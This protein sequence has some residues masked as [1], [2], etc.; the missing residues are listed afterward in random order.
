MVERKSNDN[1]NELSQ[2]KLFFSSLELFDWIFIVIFFLILIF[3][4][5]LI[6]FDVDKLDPLSTFLFLIIHMFFAVYIAVR[7][8]KKTVADK[9]IEVQKSIAKT[10]IRQII[11]SKEILQN[12]IKEIMRKTKKSTSK[13]MKETFIEIINYL[14]NL[15][16][17]LDSSEFAFDDIIGD[18][19]DKENIGR[20][21]IEELNNS[22]NE[23]MKEF[24]ELNKQS[25]KKAKNR[26]EKLEG[27]ILKLKETIFNEKSSLPITG[28]VFKDSEYHPIAPYLREYSRKVLF[29]PSGPKTLFSWDEDQSE[30]VELGSPLGYQ[31]KQGVADEK[32][33]KTKEKAKK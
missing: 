24:F 15:K 3:H 5:I 27:E 7:I 17:N 4:F 31:D 33:K 10:A 28:T 22:L 29:G 2:F 9:T 32:E 6:L 16:I 30:L 13:Q 26:A 18:E 21:K 11:S 19:I 23:K 8:T 1:K 12:I 20:R 14:Q 25:E